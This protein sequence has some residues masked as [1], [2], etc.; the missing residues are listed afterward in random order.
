MAHNTCMENP[1]ETGIP[2]LLLPPASSRHPEGS[3]WRI[4]S[5]VRRETSAPRQCLAV[6]ASISGCE[7]GLHFCPGTCLKPIRPNFE[8][9]PDLPPAG[10]AKQRIP[11]VDKVPAARP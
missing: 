4:F 10:A 1:A 9:A 5:T 3:S 7:I 2:A 6:E 11:G 8:R